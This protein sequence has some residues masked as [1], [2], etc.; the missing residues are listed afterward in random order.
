M[1]LGL[2]SD[3]HIG[4]LG[5][6]LSQRHAFLERKHIMMKRL[7]RLATRP[8]SWFQV[9]LWFLHSH[10]YSCYWLLLLADIFAVYVVVL[11]NHPVSCSPCM[12]FAKPSGCIRGLQCEFCHFPHQAA[13]RRPG[14]QPRTTSTGKGISKWEAPCDHS[15]QYHVNHVTIESTN[16]SDNSHNGSQW[17]IMTGRWI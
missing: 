6:L 7:F 11:R 10:R 12:F 14:Q 1:C 3:N 5:E 2:T 16:T 13:A 8:Y 9:V 4:Q 17:N 15:W